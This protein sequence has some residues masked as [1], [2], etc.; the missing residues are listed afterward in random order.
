MAPLSKVR[1]VPAIP[2]CI[3][4]AESTTSSGYMGGV[5]VEEQ[6][7]GVGEAWSMF[8]LTTRGAVVGQVGC[9][10]ADPAVYRLC[11]LELEMYT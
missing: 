9:T 7:A 10:L 1:S 5:E 8:T 11:C 6:N 4:P 3:V 2:D